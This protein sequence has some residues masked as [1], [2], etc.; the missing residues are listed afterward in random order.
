[1]L[2]TGKVYVICGCLNVRL[3]QISRNL[4]LLDASIEDVLRRNVRT[5]AGLDVSFDRPVRKVQET[6]PA[7]QLAQALRLFEPTC[8][9]LS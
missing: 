3:Q 8:H 2:P 7:L 4:T 1:M 5:L 6:C 9:G